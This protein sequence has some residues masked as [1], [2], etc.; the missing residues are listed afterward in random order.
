LRLDDVSAATLRAVGQSVVL[1][2]LLDAF[3]I[4]FNLLM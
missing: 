4:L 3:F 2:V 1:C